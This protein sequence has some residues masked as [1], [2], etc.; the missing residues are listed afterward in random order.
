MKLEKQ[1]II[2]KV[3]KLLALSE[4]TDQGPEAESAKSKAASLMAEY[5][6]NI[7]QAKEKPEFS[8]INEQLTR[9][10]PKKYE[11]IL[12]NTI[13]IFNG[14]S[15]IV[16]TGGGKAGVNTFVGTD[17]DLSCNEYM[18][19]I[20]KQQR[21]HTWKKF[22][23]EYKAQRG[24]SPSKSDRN[25]WFMGFSF[26]ISSK[27]MN[28]TK[29]KNDKIQEYGLVPVSASD[30]ALSHYKKDSEV[31]KIKSKPSVYNREGFTAG[32][33]AHI[34]KGIDNAGKSTLQLT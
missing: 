1:K 5:D 8:T 12:V 10:A 23:S 28:L 22:L 26:G 14:V 29:M 6:I 7:M 21:T 19:D 15:Y 33:N 20:V 3:V 32:K 24:S 27:L 17:N 31:G 16:C 2:D 25:K 18:I 13:S 11:R 30:A 34:H 4:G 9:K